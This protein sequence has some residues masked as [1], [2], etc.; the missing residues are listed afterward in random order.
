LRNTVLEL[1]RQKLIR[2]ETNFSIFFGSSLVIVV[3]LIGISLY[4]IIGEVSYRLLISA[5][6]D[7]EVINAIWLSIKTST[8]ATLIST[9]IG[10]PSGYFLS[11]HTFIG[12]NIIDVV[13][14]IPIILPPLVSG[15][16]LLIFFG[17]TYIGRILSGYFG[18]LFSEKG[19]ILAQT[20]IALP[21]IIKTSKGI[22]DGMDIMYERVAESF[23]YKGDYIFYKIVIPT[24]WKGIISGILLGFG[25]AIGE[26]GATLMIAGATR[27]KTETMPI[28]I[29][30]S[31]STGEIEKAIAIALIQL[32][33]ALII[34]GGAKGYLKA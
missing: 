16:S 23:G 25:R 17:N 7:K 20:F 3:I 14:N 31:V 2:K 30:L 32:S 29:Y 33:I 34:I 18:I 9:I 13:I 4:S 21:F 1:L 8:I 22:F 12:K 26:F 11:R 5:F 15:F 19:I 27:F 28:A 6:Q 10:I 24:G